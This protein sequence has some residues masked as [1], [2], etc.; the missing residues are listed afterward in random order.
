MLIQ[1]SINAENGDDRV[2][3]ESRLYQDMADYSGKVVT[4]ETLDLQ[5]TLFLGAI[6]SVLPGK[7]KGKLQPYIK[8]LLRDISTM[9]SL[10]NAEY[11]ECKFNKEGFHDPRRAELRRLMKLILEAWSNYHGKVQL[12][13]CELDQTL[14]KAQSG[15]TNRMIATKTRTP[16]FFDVKEAEE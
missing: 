6:T 13:K 12:M 4:A 5:E 7:P 15:N 2:E 3:V 16:L 10:V 11:I 9:L 8:Q 1:F 14:S